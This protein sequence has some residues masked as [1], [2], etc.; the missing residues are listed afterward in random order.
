MIVLFGIAGAGKSVQG[1]LLADRLGYKWI[2]TGEF[3]RRQISPKRHQEMIKGKL[4][5]DE[6][7][8]DILTKLFKDLDS[9]K[10]VILDG[11]PRTQI[12]ADWLL[13]QHKKNSVKLTAVINLIA[14]QQVVKDRL[15]TRSR[16]DDQPEA[17]KK[18]FLE[19]KQ[20]T[21]PIVENFKKTGI[22]VHNVN[23]EDTVEEVQTNIR[24]ALRV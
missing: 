15:L 8:I 6:E 13:D 12:Q 9:K 10:E 18:R 3:L 11:F 19:F 24:Q 2:S 7:V 16:P 17:I 21:M 4:L 20:T 14:S 22:P 5:K 1:K 23:A